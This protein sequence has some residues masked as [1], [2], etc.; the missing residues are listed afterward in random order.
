VWALRPLGTFRQAPVK[1]NS[2]LRRHRCLA[3]NTQE[4]TLDLAGGAQVRI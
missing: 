2:K 3:A 1:L 4:V